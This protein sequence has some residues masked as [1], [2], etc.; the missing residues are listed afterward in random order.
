MK[1]LHRKLPLWMLLLIPIFV[2]FTSYSDGPPPSR[3]GAPGELTCLNGYCHNSFQVNSGLGIISLSGQEAERF[4]PGNA[5]QLRLSV[6]DSGLAAFGFSVSARVAATGEQAGNWSYTPGVQV[7]EEKGRQY[8]MHDTVKVVDHAVQWQLEWTAPDSLIG[9]V[10][11]Y[12]AAV[13]AN[14]NGNRQG[15]YVYTR[16]I[17]LLP[18][19]ISAKVSHPQSRISWVQDQGHLVIQAPDPSAITD[20]QIWDL[21]G[22]M[23]WQDRLRASE[24]KVEISAW[25]KQVYLVKL[26]QGDKAFTGKVRLF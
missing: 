2:L 9:P 10:D 4:V 6:A 3:T 19:S 12:V 15:D 16:K 17:T 20:L 7:K 1:P 8:L 13:A 5:F 24:A 18:D 25:P 21:S 11:F 26:R 23:L 22:R 14:A